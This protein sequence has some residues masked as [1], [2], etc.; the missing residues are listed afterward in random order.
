MMKLIF[1]KSFHHLQNKQPL[2]RDP[3]KGKMYKINNTIILVYN[4]PYR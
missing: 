2:K 3:E 4:Q 1:S